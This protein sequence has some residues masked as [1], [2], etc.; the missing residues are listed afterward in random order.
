MPLTFYTLL[1]FNRD[2]FC[3]GFRSILVSST[4]F[5]LE[6]YYVKATP[7]LRRSSLATT[8]VFISLIFAELI[9]PTKLLDYCEKLELVLFLFFKASIG[10][11]L[12]DANLIED[13]PK[14]RSSPFLPSMLCKIDSLLF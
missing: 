1:F 12:S 3:S 5:L 9:T 10:V 4:V 8:S 11:A 14:A 13:Y 2:G 6:L 7:I